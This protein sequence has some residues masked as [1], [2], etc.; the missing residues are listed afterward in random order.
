MKIL[1]YLLLLGFMIIFNTQTFAQDH[2]HHVKHNMILLGQT[3]VYATHIVYKVPH[4]YQV[5]LRINFEQEM[6]QR[7]LSEKL[8]YPDDQ[9]ILLLDNM[10]ISNIA[11]VENIS[12]Q[13][14][15]ESSDGTK[16]II[17]DTVIS[18]DNFKII[19]FDELPT[20]LGI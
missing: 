2:S 7:Y 12:G 1:I 9:F 10:D 5:I 20:N 14:F 18:K 16:N 11:D 19:F 8:K 17:G 3:E 4:N 13:I 6:N 15:R